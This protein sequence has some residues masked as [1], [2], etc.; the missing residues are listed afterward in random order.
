MPDDANSGG[1]RSPTALRDYQRAAVD[2]VDPALPRGQII[3]AC[4]VGK[5]L[6]ALASAV[7]LLDGRPGSVLVLFP[8]L[9]L[10]EQ[11]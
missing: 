10:M 4:G 11:T 3:A 1:D 9:G 2:T 7:K 6:I 8:T 5:T